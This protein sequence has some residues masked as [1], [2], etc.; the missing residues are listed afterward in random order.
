MPDVELYQFI[1]DNIDFSEASDARRLI[2]DLASFLLPQVNNLTF[3]TTVD[4]SQQATVTSE[5][6]LYF[7]NKFLDII[8]PDPE[9]AWTDRYT[10]QQGINTME[11]QLHN[12][13]NAMLQSPEYQLQ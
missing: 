9:A 5:R 12:L 11:G 8:D 4:E 3:D 6:L 10:N 1:R 7:L 2:I 13:F